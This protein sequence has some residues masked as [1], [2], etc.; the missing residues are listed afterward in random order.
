MDIVAIS[1][2]RWDFVWQRP[3]HLMSRAARRHRVLFV[4]EPAKGNAF[5]L[6]RRHALPNLTVLRPR[7][8]KELS[9]AGAEAAIA[10]LLRHEVA[11][12]AQSA[13]LVLW[14]LS[15]MGEPLSRSLE[16]ALTVYDCMDELSAFRDAPPDLLERER[17]LM[18][19]A[20]LVFTGGH[21]LYEAKRPHHPRV[22]S[23]PSSVDVA[24][25]ARARAEQP[26]PE[27][28]AGIGHPRLMYAGVIDE[29]LDMRLIDR[30]GSS[31][32]GE[33]V[34]VGPVAKIDKADVPRGPHIHR[35]GMQ[36]YDRLP[37]L[38]AHADVGLMPF[39]MNEAT[40]FISPTKTPEYLAAG[41]PVV[42]TPVA[43]V[44]RTYGGLDAVR[45]ALDHDGFIE[46]CEAALRHRGPSREADRL[47]AG[48]SWDATW[49][50]MEGHMAEALGERT[51][52]PDHPQQ[53]TD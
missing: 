15:V 46:A 38:F 43:D 9:E 36:P 21:S 27:E 22:H 44:V 3:Q 19:R 11:G 32:V 34:L 33:V 48:M 37:A 16:P 12:W 47:L 29:R 17:R 2:L 41:L 28:L 51:S 39:A 13:P 49:A 7:L 6:V 45:I 23:F 20:E 30:L 31:G 24:H 53:R 4:E 25:F 18:A 8:P 1:H 52:T 42:S 40:R 50:A 10:Q 35:L 26:E 5:K 14:H